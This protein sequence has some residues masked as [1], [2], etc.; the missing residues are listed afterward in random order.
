MKNHKIY[1]T[2]RNAYLYKDGCMI[3]PTAFQEDNFCQA[4]FQ[5][6]LFKF[7][8]IDNFN[9]EI[10]LIDAIFILYYFCRIGRHFLISS[11]VVSQN[12]NDF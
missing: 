1:L 9:C 3:K 8:M 4:I 6:A 5:P 12:L 7:P 2:R 10:T 11:G